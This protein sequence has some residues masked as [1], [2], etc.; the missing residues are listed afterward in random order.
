MNTFYKYYSGELEA[1]LPTIFIGGN[2]EA[3]NHLWELPYGGW[4]AKNIFYLGFG[5]VVTFGGVRIA[6]L[7]GIFNDNHYKS[8]TRCTRCL[9]STPLRLPICGP[10]FGATV[11][12][13]S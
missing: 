1:P 12:C 8:A 13:N 3:S 4:V 2:H 6:G 9:L 11:H 5:G 7:S 10:A